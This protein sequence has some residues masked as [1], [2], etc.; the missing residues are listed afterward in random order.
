MDID[1]TLKGIKLTEEKVREIFETICSVDINDNI[2]YEIEDI[3][4]IRKD[5]EYG[6]LIRSFIGRY[7]NGR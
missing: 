5:D 3:S 4:E 6:G 7:N 1:T 2:S